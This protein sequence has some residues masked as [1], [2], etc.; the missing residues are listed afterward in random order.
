MILFVDDQAILVNSKYSMYKRIIL[1]DGFVF[2][3]SQ[4]THALQQYSSIRDDATERLCHQG[5]FLRKNVFA[6]K[7]SSNDVEYLEGYIKVAPPMNGA[8]SAVE[9]MIQFT[10]MLS[11]YDI[12]IEEYI[13]SFFGKID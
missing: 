2:S 8:E 12:S 10:T 7:T 13:Q 5:V 3:K 4:L 6:R 9:Q 1:L 11:Q